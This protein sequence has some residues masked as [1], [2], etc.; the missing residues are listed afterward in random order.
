MILTN[1]Q[2]AA[3]ARAQA[4]AGDLPRP[5][6]A[7]PAAGRAADR[8]ARTRSGCRRRRCAGALAPQ[9]GGRARRRGEPAGRGA[10]PRGAATAARR[11]HRSCSAPSSRPTTASATAAT[12]GSAAPPTATSPRRSAA[13]RTWS[14]TGRCWRRS[15]EGEEAP[16]AG[17]G[18]RG[19]RATAASAS[20]SRCGSSATPTTSAPPSCS[21]ASCAERG[22]EAEFEGEVSGVIRAG[23]FVAFGGELGDVYEGFLPGPA[24]AAA[25]ASS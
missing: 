10:R 20:A 9:R 13:T 15:G 4:G 22:A 2:V 1:E 16:R 8:P 7:R 17:R 25:S 19:R 6:P 23:A 12:P 5:R 14:S 3:A 24:D 21:S 11:I 18:A